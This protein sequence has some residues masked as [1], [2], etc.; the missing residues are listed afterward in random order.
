MD[1]L[2]S[3][4]NEKSKDDIAKNLAHEIETTESS[5]N[6]SIVAAAV[7]YLDQ[8]EAQEKTVT[9]DSGQD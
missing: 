9:P 8:I 4:T 3:K 1:D 7:V 6:D 2:S 5:A